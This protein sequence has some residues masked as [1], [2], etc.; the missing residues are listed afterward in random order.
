MRRTYYDIQTGDVH[1]EATLKFKGRINATLY[2]MSIGEW[3][4]EILDSG[5]YEHEVVEGSIKIENIEN[6]YEEME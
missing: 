1:I 5:D 4:S 3:V 6:D 2:E